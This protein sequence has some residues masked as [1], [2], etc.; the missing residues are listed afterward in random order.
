[1]KKIFSILPVMAVVMLL[2]YACNKKNDVVE[3]NGAGSKSFRSEVSCE[4][5]CCDTTERTKTIDGSVGLLRPGQS[6]GPFNPIYF[7]FCTGT[8]SSSSS[9]DQQI[10][11]SGTFNSTVTGINGWKV[12][13][14]NGS[15]CSCLA[16]ENDSITQAQINTNLGS[17]CGN[18]LGWNN[19]P[20][21]PSCRGWY[22]Y[23][24][25]GGAFEQVN[26]IV[27]FKDCNNN[28]ILDAG[29]PAYIV[30]LDVATEEVYDDDEELIGY[31]GVYTARYKCLVF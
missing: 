16:A 27:V 22:N 4:T 5:S 17:V 25:P 26:C 14:L 23:T 2:A 21:T 7:D 18:A 11:M 6:P 19:S 9:S 30:C 8:S 20:Y 28:G 24:P 13:Y 1:M 3:P 31:K 15:D 12:S 29:E 10:S